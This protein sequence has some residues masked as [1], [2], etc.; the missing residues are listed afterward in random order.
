MFLCFKILHNFLLLF[1]SGDQGFLNS[2]YAGFANAHVF[3]PDLKPEALNSRPVPEMERL[4]TLYN[5]DVGL[6]MLANKVPS[7]S[8][9]LS[10]H[11]HVS[12]PPLFI[13]GQGNLYFILQN[14]KFCS[15]CFAR[16]F[17]HV[18]SI[19]SYLCWFLS[20]MDCGFKS[21]DPWSH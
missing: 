20:S 8:F 11:M 7:L 21:F 17:V 16:E 15:P 4:S 1:L 6:Y 5:A 12:W 18:L 10:L 2:Y 13:C 3:Q 9:S 14:Y 19:E